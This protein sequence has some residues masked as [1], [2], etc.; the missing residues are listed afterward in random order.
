MSPRR[1]KSICNAAYQQKSRWQKE[2]Y[3]ETHAKAHSLC[4]WIWICLCICI[5]ICIWIWIGWNQ[6]AGI[7]EQ[8]ECQ[9]MQ[10]ALNAF[11]DAVIWFRYPPILAVCGCGCLCRLSI[12]VRERKFLLRVFA[13]FPK[14]NLIIIRTHRLL[15]LAKMSFESWKTRI[16]CLPASIRFR[17]IIL[18]AVVMPLAWLPSFT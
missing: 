14:A 11:D 13:S 9:A 12:S 8:K 5:C 15:A 18:L 4:I 16:C 3:P 2:K 6:G 7:S 17:L 1:W 10:I